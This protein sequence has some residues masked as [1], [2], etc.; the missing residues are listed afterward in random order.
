MSSPSS[1]AAGFVHATLESPPR[2]IRAPNAEPVRIK[3][4]PTMKHAPIVYLVTIPVPPRY[5]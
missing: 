5:S 1:G 2:P 3:N 4:A